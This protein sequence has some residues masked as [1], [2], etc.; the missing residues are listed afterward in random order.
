MESNH[1]RPHHYQAQMINELIGIFDET[2]PLRKLFRNFTEFQFCIEIITQNGPI[3]ECVNAGL[4]LRHTES[5]LGMIEN[6]IE[7]KP[8]DDGIE[9]KSFSP[10]HSAMLLPIKYPRNI[11]ESLPFPSNTE[12][13]IS[14]GPIER[15]LTNVLLANVVYYYSLYVESKYLGQ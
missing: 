7:I 6:D 12:V 1:F 4:L 15:I 13:Y 8:I 10:N 11:L 5:V 14:E 2:S 3:H 9:I